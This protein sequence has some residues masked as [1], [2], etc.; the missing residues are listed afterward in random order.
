MRPLNLASSPARNFARTVPTTSSVIVR[1][2][3]S[4]VSTRTR[5]VGRLAEFS[6]SCFE[7][8][9][10]SANAT[11]AVGRKAKVLGIDRFISFADRLGIK[12]GQ[13]ERL[14]QGSNG[15]ALIRLGFG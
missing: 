3:F 14:A 4:M 1:D 6:F 15:D 9:P 13:R 12:L 10:T 7:P 5:A 8:Q 11:T 2:L